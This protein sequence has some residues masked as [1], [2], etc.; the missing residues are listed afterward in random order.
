MSS[1]KWLPFCLG[2]N[3]LNKQQYLDLKIGH[4]ESSSG[5]DCQGDMPN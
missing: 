1:G 2:F 4:Q 3:V 5:N